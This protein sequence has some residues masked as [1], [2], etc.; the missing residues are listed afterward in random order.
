MAQV[1]ASVPPRCSRRRLF[2]ALRSRGWRSA[3][4]SLGV[5]GQIGDSRSRSS[6]GARAQGRRRPHPGS[7]R[8]AGPDRLP[9]LQRAG[10]VYSLLRLAHCG[11]LPVKPVTVLG[12][13]RIHRAAHA[14]ARLQLPGGVLGWRGWPRA[15]PTSTLI[16][17]LCRKPRRAV[18]LL[19]PAA[20]D[21]ARPAL[22]PPTD[23]SCSGAGGLVSARARGDRRRRGL[24]AG[25]RGRALPTMAAIQAGRPW[26]SPTRRRW[27]WPGPHDRGRPRARRDAP[28][29][30]LR[31]QRRLPVPGGPR[32]RR[33]S[34]P[35]A[36]RLR[37]AVPRMP[38]PPR[39]VTVEE[40]LQHPTWKMG[41]KI[42]IDS[43]TLMNKGLEVIEARWLFDVP[44]E[45]VHVVVHPSR[46]STRWSST[47]T[48]GDRPARRGRHGHPILYALTYPERLPTPA[49]GSTWYSSATLTFEEPDDGVP[50]PCRWRGP[51]LEAGGA[52]R[53]SSMRRTSVAVAAVPRARRIGFDARSRPL[54]QEALDGPCALRGPV[55]SDRG[56][57]RCDRRRRPPALSWSIDARPGGSSCGTTI[58]SFVVVI[59]ILILIHEL[60]HFFVARWRRGRRA[61]LD[62]LRPGALAFG[63]A[64]RPSTACR[65]FRWAAT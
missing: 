40:A 44:F 54:I 14:R 58:L 25:G 56:L 23:P 51:R 57:R 59:G 16:A 7:R 33:G 46:S 31:A 32:S 2:P 45:Q 6:S 63:A 41:A 4:G 38:R 49:P 1:V 12:R 62:R 17:D 28:P 15:A 9:A 21:R 11:A 35:R 60:G 3:R 48:V 55:R 22:P 36:H 18:A 64:R 8:R 39:A 27:S 24:R 61:V 19:D 5:V 10:P 50:L 42:T 47:S 13:D 52:R 26:R 37:G 29:G 30:R 53:S 65:P 43:A 20:V 34:P